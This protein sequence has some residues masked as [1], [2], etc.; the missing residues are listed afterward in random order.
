MPVNLQTTF[1]KVPYE[2]SKNFETLAGAVNVLEQKVA[3]LKPAT[4]LNEIVAELK[5]LS[6]RVDTL[7]RQVQALQAAP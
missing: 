4:G 1:N 6:G 3:D 5:A 2:V 7:N